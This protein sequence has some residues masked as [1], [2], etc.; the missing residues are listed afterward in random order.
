MERLASREVAVDTVIAIGFLV[1]GLTTRLEIQDA[2]LGP[3]SRARTP[4]T[5]GSW[6]ATRCRSRC[7]VCSR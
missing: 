4:S 5:S 3:F 2:G 7:A 1:L 6:S